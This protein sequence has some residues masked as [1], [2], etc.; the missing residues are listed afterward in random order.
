MSGTD[1]RRDSFQK[2]TGPTQY[3]LIAEALAN[4]HYMESSH[5]TI[6]HALLY[7]SGLHDVPFRELPS[8]YP[9]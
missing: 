6:L 8:G 2:S 1:A 5:D 7:Y 4:N 3:V 9:R